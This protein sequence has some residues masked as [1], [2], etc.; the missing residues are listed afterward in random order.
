MFSE[1]CLFLLF[2]NDVV[3]RNRVSY[4]VV[5]CRCGITSFYKPYT[6]SVYDHDEPLDNLT[7]EMYKE[8]KLPSAKCKARF[9]DHCALPT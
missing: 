2:S 7:A 1:C 8:G 6:R 5:V 4:V 9:L 3:F